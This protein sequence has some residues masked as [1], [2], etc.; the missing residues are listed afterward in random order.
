MDTEAA[1][2]PSAE[3]L[4]EAAAILNSIS[5]SLIQGDL[6]D[7][8]ELEEVV[9]AGKVRENGCYV[10]RERAD[11]LLLWPGSFRP[12]HHAGAFR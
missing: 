11:P 7:Q 5:P 3:K 2:L 12:L 8:P 4:R 9:S 1:P 10:D 6:A